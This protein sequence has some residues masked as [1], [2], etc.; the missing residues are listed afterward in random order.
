MFGQI[1]RHGGICRSQLY[2]DWFIMVRFFFFC[3]TLN[4]F[5]FLWH[6]TL[7]YSGVTHLFIFRPFKTFPRSLAN[8]ANFT[9]LTLISRRV[10]LFCVRTHGDFILHTSITISVFL[11]SSGYFL[12]SPWNR[13]LWQT[14]L[15]LRAS[16]SCLVNPYPWPAAFPYLTNK[17]RCLGVKRCNLFLFLQIRFSSQSF[18]SVTLTSSRSFTNIGF[19]RRKSFSSQTTVGRISLCRNSIA[20][21]K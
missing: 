18:W 16:I 5:L 14:S 13:V 10:N 9:L 8:H 4:L 21:R 12:S 1:G 6:A 19:W 20:W 2:K 15:T 11:S 3:S 17:H 7:S